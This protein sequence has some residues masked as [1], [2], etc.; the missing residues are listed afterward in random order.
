LV[1]SKYGSGDLPNNFIIN[2]KHIK[3]KEEEKLAPLQAVQR[4]VDK[5]W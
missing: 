3:K 1:H 4:E 5:S 2:A